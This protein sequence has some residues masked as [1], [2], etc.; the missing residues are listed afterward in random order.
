LN[1]QVTSGCL[2]YSPMV[3]NTSVENTFTIP[4][5]DVLF[6]GEV[7]TITGSQS[8]DLTLNRI[9]I[10]PPSMYL[11]ETPASLY[12]VFLEIWYQNLDPTT[13]Q[14]YYTDPVSGALYYF[15]YGGVSPDPSAFTGTTWDD[16]SLSLDANNQSVY[17][18]AR[19][20]IQWRL[21]VQEVALT[22][23]FTKY[24]YGIDPGAI[25]TEIV[26]AQAA[27]PTATLGM[28]PLNGDPTYQFINM[29]TVT[30][31]TGLWQA[32]DGNVN[33]SLGTMDGYSYAMPIAVV[34]QKNSGA[35]DLSTNIFGCADAQSSTPT[36]LIAYGV[37]GR[38]D[39]KLADQIFADDVV[40]TRQTVQLDGWDYD[41][42]VRDGFSDLVLGNSRNKIAR[43][44]APGMNSTALG[45]IL[46]YYVSV[47]PVNTSGGV[48]IVGTWDGFANGFSSDARSYT[49]SKRV[50]TTQKTT[51][52]IGGNWAQGDTFIVALPVS[53][54]AA[55]T[56]LSIQALV[57]R[58]GGG[59]TPVTIL[60]GQVTITGLGTT[61][62]AVN[63]SSN[64]T[65]TPF[66]PGSNPI[67]VA[68]TVQYPAGTGIDLRKT[69]IS[70][71]GG[72]LT[73]S[74]LGQGIPIFGVSEYAVQSD[75][76]PTQALRVTSIN[77]KYSDTFLGTKIWVTV[78]G[79]LG[80]SITT[81]GVTLTTFSIDRTGGG[82]GLDNGINGFYPTH[83]WDYATGAQYTIYKCAMNAS[84][85]VI[86]L[87]G[88]VPTTSTL[89]MSFLAQGTA[90]LAYNAPVRGV[91]EIEETVL[92]GNYTGTTQFPMDTRVTVPSV[93]YDPLSNSS[94][95][96]LAAT[97]CVIKG[98]S[99][100]NINKYIWLSDSVGNLTC[101]PVAQPNFS[102]GVVSVVVPGVNLIPSTGAINF[103][104]CGSIL[105]AL[106]AAS[107]LV[108]QEQYVPY[109]GVGVSGRD[110]EVVHTEDNALI[111]TNGTGAA[112]VPGISD[113]YPYN[114][115]L[116]IVTMLPAQ[117]TWQDST[118]TNSPLSTYFDSNYVAM[119]MSNVEHT[120]LAPLH[121]NDFIQPITRDIKKSI[122]LVTEGGNRGFSIATPHVG[123]AIAPPAL[124]S[125][126]GQ[127]LQATTTPVT[128]YVDN[129][130]GNDTYDGAS[131]QTAKASFMAA[132]NALPSALLHPCAIRIRNTGV[133]Y[134]LTN[135]QTIA[136][137]DGAIQ[138]LKYYALAN[139][140]FTIQ[141]EGRL[142]ITRDTDSSEG[143]VTID[144][145][146]FAG[147]GDGQTTAFFINDSRVLFNGI[148]FKGFSTA[149]TS[150]AVTAID[151]DVE[152]ISCSWVG[153]LQAGAFEE[154]SGVIISNS[155]ITLSD[156]TNGIVVSQSSLTVS[157]TQLEVDAVT[158]IPGGFFVGERNSSVSLQTHSASAEINVS[159]STVIAEAQFNSSI[160]VTGDFSSNGMAAL[161]AASTLSRTM[162]VT[163]FAGGIT[164]DASCS[165]VTQ[166]QG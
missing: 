115:E 52:I 84:Q 148:Q 29:G 132:V 98:I 97:E 13:G 47:A 9:I 103:L 21:N 156:N 146:G 71:Q 62:V 124:R 28:S 158:S 134:S 37:S 152:F 125:V 150:T 153:N 35:F 93:S 162:K 22:Y 78:A 144:A 129:V 130:N 85:C 99:G 139:I 121:V 18:T 53:S 86:T 49:V 57:S 45:S 143:T 5:F 51:G 142:I 30:G 59:V 87:Q 161:Q 137:G 95:V 38:F 119:R 77:P 91:T 66:D 88:G 60:P 33:N 8:T 72:V 1:D 94:T 166:L 41:K 40:D 64:L 155:A 81:G 114:R 19:A 160:E 15:P 55:I 133:A 16:D 123:F 126:L 76:K 154:G 140:A 3:F 136:L 34:F 151:S 2:T 32:G 7:V 48:D 110:Y 102:G 17:T 63:L 163:P 113:V 89:V 80:V 118:L 73:D 70:V 157:N 31:D 101:C 92:F 116:P 12:V 58:L 108:I 36:G 54:S 79:A 120:F 69:L 65:N 141:Q 122:R 147:F 83:V 25:P 75:H 100:N 96:V 106:S 90:Q 42:L 104:F 68:L 50:V 27:L 145:T 135:L 112:P 43:G 67:Y 23:D 128:L 149:T 14:G 159:N 82:N 138:P 111:T 26:Y 6:N 74:T 11:P 117:V 44:E 4:S 164:S 107:S 105:P 10:P 109:Q 131:S 24:Q 165:V 61:S 56:S 39:S 20:Q 127:N 46:D